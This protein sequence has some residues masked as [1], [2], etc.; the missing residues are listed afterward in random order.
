MSTAT[1]GKSWLPTPAALLSVALVVVGLVASTVATSLAIDAGEVPV[2]VLP[3]GQ[4]LVEYGLPVLVA[5]RLVSVVVVW[6]IAVRT[7]PRLRYWLLSS[8][9][10][11]W[12]LWG[13]WQAWVLLART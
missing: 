1:D 12:L 3:F 7:A 10:L 4:L 2:T 11:F 8:A 5:G 13:V 6:F 9:G